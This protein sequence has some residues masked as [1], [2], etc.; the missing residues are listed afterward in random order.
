MNMKKN[1]TSAVLI[2]GPSGSII[3]IEKLLPAS[4]ML[5]VVLKK[6]PL[7]PCCCVVNLLSGF[8]GLFS[9]GHAG[10]ML[11]GAYTYAIHH[12][13]GLPCGSISIL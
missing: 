11:I 10:F 6:V 5:F 13:D 2:R 12:T 8:T 4:S 9:L 3:C 1:N 7:C